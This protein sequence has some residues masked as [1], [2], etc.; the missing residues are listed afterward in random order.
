LISSLCDRIRHAIRRRRW[1]VERSNGVRGED[2]AMR[3]LQKRKFTVVA[4]NYKPRSGHGEIDIIAWD[5]D[6]LVFVEVKSSVDDERGT[7][8]R[9]VDRY[10]REALEW[11]ARSYLALV[12]VPWEQSRFD[13]VTVVGAN[14]PQIEHYPA[15]F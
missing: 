2:L 8:D 15:A 7:P 11:A 12:R 6:T 10:K 1:T 14:P 3:F 13:I 9:A 4:R 5:G